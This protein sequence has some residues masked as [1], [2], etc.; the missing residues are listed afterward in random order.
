MKTFLLAIQPLLLT[1]IRAQQFDALIPSC[2]VCLIESHYSRSS[3][4][5][6]S[7]PATKTQSHSLVAPLLIMSA[8]VDQLPKQ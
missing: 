5:H 2:A 3:L 1:L 6:S 8:N 4:T 7:S